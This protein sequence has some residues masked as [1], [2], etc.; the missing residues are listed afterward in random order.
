MEFFSRKQVKQH[1]T[2]EDCWI[3]IGNEVY[4]IT[5]FM[6]THPGKNAPMVVAGQD[7]TLMFKK[8]HP[9]RVHKSINSP[10]FCDLYMVGYIE[11]ESI[12][13]KITTFLYELTSSNN[14]K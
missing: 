10:T 1:N 5:E 7:A 6:K 8:I 4:D 3:I 9:V 13:R 14:G 12:L 2:K 11:E